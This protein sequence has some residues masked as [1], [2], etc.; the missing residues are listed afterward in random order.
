MTEG[1]FRTQ[2]E[3]FFETIEEETG[4]TEADFR[5]LVESSLLQE[6]VEA[7]LKAEMPTVAEQVH[8]RHILVATEEE[9]LA[10]IER[11]N[12]GEDFAALATELSTDTASGAEGGDLGWFGRGQMVAAFEDV[13]FSLEPGQRSDPVASEFGYH[14]I[15]VLER[16]DARALEGDALT[17]FQSEQLEAWYSA[18]EAADVA[19]YWTA[20]MVPA[21]P[22]PAG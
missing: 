1:E 15:E 11:L 12:A 10:A 3:T 6:K 5:A 2:T 8:A 22:Y 7:A 4:F 9:A 18:R 19:R 21:D 13:A 16:D 17:A 20:D 14:I